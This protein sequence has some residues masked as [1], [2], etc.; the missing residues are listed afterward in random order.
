[1]AS[2]VG[3]NIVAGFIIDSTSLFGTEKLNPGRVFS[4]PLVGGNPT[5]L[6]SNLQFPPALATDGTFLYYSGDLNNSVNGG[7]GA[8]VK[9]AKTGGAITK[10][11]CVTDL[12]NPAGTVYN[13]NTLAA[14]ATNVYLIG[15]PNGGAGA[16]PIGILKAPKP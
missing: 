10:G 13:A 14:D 3:S 5:Y 6:A 2:N 1:M 11:L 4:V 16:G 12:A 8:I 7:P 9:M 15:Y